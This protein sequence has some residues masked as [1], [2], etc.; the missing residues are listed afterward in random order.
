MISLSVTGKRIKERRKQLGISADDI[1]E[2]LAISRS[3]VYRWENG[4]IDKIP[5]TVIKTLAI[6]LHTTPAYLIF[7]SFMEQVEG[8]EPSS[9][10]WKAEVIAIIRHLHKI[11]F[12]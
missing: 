12:I 8:I 2:E 1:A 11:F 5:I 4:D 6:L 3:T 7:K 10:A 9:S